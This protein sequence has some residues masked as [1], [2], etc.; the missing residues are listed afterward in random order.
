VAP[1]STPSAQVRCHIVSSNTRS[2]QSHIPPVLRSTRSGRKHDRSVRWSTASARG[3][4]DSVISPRGWRKI[5]RR[6]AV[7][8]VTDIFIAGGL[9]C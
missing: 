2:G 7:L 5:A 9:C 4:S 8:G 1:K 3:R 6:M